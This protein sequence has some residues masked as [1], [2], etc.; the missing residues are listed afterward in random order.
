MNYMNSLA[1]VSINCLALNIYLLK[2]CIGKKIELQPESD[3][4][5]V[6]DLRSQHIIGKIEQRLTGPRYSQRKPVVS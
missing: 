5:V 1:C 4:N 3:I 2:G 6:C